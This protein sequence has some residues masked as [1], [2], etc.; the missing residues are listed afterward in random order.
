[1]K[2]L[3]DLLGWLHPPY[4]NIDPRT[5]EWF[6]LSGAG[7]I[8][9]IL[10]AYI[11]ICTSA[12]ERYMKDKQPYDLRKI[13][14]VYNFIQILISIYIF[15]EGLMAGWLYDFSYTCQPNDYSESESA[16]RIARACHSYFL[17]KLF[18]LLDTLFFVLRKKQRQITFLHL[19]HHTVMLLS[20]WVGTRYF[21]GTLH[22]TFLGLANSFVHIIMYG[23]Y[24][25]TAFGPEM[26][27]SLMAWKKYLTI[28]QI[29]QFGAVG[30]HAAQIFFIECDVSKL[31]ATLVCLNSIIFI[32][33]F[34]SFYIQNY[35]KSDTNHVRNTSSSKTGYTSK[36]SE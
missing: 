5:N 12:G 16:M 20:T 8:T 24:M 32:Y 13:L 25:L 4:N 34:S 19:Y 7:P 1:M 23:Y 22:L 29:V 27:K 18:E 17:V 10:V 28:M 35:C 2:M 21:S 33:L 30:I 9:I 26:Q 31:L 36:K 3:D 11:Y 14:I 6:L 15:K